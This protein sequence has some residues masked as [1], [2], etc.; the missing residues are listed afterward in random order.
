[1]ASVCRL[2]LDVL[3]PHKPNAYDFTLTLAGLAM[4]KH[5]VGL[6]RLSQSQPIQRPYF[7]PSTDLC[8]LTE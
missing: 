1:M 4:L 6:I 3:R 7:A 5:L 8:F 2:C